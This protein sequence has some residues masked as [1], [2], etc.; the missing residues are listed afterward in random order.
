MPFSSV[1]SIL[2]ISNDLSRLSA[3]EKG[4]EGI[5]MIH[6][7]TWR[8]GF[9]MGVLV[10]LWT[11]LF[12]YLAWA[13]I[14]PIHPGPANIGYGFLL[15][16]PFGLMAFLMVLLVFFRSTRTLSFGLA[17]PLLILQIGLILLTLRLGLQVTFLFNLP[18]GLALLIVGMAF[19][20]NSVRHSRERLKTRES[21]NERE[22]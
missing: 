4:K 1:T 9:F 16:A 8:L 3:R 22:K 21:F 5:H 17:V 15:I 2:E 7:A 12:P 14:V 18:S 13:G 6:D 11:F 20:L 19:S 10:L